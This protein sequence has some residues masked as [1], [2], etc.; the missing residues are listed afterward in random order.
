[1]FYRRA[2]SLQVAF[3]CLAIMSKSA[4][5]LA[6][7]FMCDELPISYNFSVSPDKCPYEKGDI[8]TATLHVSIVTSSPAYSTSD[9][10]M[11][12]L[13]PFQVNTELKSCRIISISEWPDVTLNA[14]KLNADITITY[15]VLKEHTRFCRYVRV[16]KLAESLN[17]G[18][19]RGNGSYEYIITGETYVYFESLKWRESARTDL[20]SAPTN[21]RCTGRASRRW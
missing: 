19:P 4:Y 1:M 10:Y 11:I 18:W 16:Y 3:L 9:I 2:T 15:E 7:D 21:S 20:D 14:S 6:E 8:I 12:D 13:N 17:D 5:L